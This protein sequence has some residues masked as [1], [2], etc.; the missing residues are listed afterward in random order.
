MDKGLLKK[1]E[2][3]CKEM[4]LTNNTNYKTHHEKNH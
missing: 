1:S 2:Y 4:D 3:I